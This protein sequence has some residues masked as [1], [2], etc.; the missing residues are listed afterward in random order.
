M[1]SEARI[2]REFHDSVWRL[3]N[4]S[5][6]MERA[7]SE[8]RDLAYTVL[9]LADPADGDHFVAEHWLNTFGRDPRKEAARPELHRKLPE[10]GG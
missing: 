9:R 5:S 2:E 8:A 4:D 10:A 6:S 3:A 7:V 1:A